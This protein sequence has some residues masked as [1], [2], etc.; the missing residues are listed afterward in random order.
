MKSECKVIDIVNSKSYVPY[1]HNIVTLR[2]PIREIQHLSDYKLQ[3]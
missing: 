1:Y 3:K 2:I